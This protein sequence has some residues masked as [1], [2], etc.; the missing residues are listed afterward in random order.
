MR[1]TGEADSWE[2]FL[3]RDISK[4]HWGE[5]AEDGEE[6]GG[7][8]EKD[9]TVTKVKSF[10]YVTWTCGSVD[11]LSGLQEREIKLAKYTTYFI[12]VTQWTIR[13]LLL[14]QKYFLKMCYL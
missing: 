8:E 7:G 10:Y 12:M 14:F 5:I 3:F 2:G 11:L 13:F 6:K 1:K 4:N 9:N